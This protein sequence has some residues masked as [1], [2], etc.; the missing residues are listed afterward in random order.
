MA[1]ERDNLGADRVWLYVAILTG[2]YLLSRG[3]AKSGAGARAS[4]DHGHGPSIA[5]RAKAAAEAGEGASVAEVETDGASLF[6]KEAGTG[7]PILLIHGIGIDAE[8]WGPIF[9]DLAHDHR[10]MPTTDVPSRVPEPS[11]WQTGPATPPGRLP[12]VQSGALGR[13]RGRHYVGARALGGAQRGN[14]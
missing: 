6:V 2:G 12:L 4:T 13:P 7:S 10:V 9:D 8:N 11:R 14:R 3:L 1:G 5:D